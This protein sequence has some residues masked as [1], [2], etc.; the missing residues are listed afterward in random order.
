MSGESASAF[1]VGAAAAGALRPFA[2]VVEEAM[3]GLDAIR[4]QQTDLRERR[5]QFRT[6][7]REETNLDDGSLNL[8][9]QIWRTSSST[10]EAISRITDS[11]NLLRDVGERWAQAKLPG[12]DG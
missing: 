9:E 12:L 1:P 4:E 3:R 10:T 2:E 5:K 8:V 7:L 11:G 6:Q